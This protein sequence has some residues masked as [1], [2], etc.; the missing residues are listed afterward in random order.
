[1]TH[2]RLKSLIG[3]KRS[4][5]IVEV[6]CAFGILHQKKPKQEEEKDDDD[7]EGEEGMTYI[8][9]KQGPKKH[10]SLCETNKLRTQLL[11][12]IQDIVNLSKRLLL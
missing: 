3:N 12:T 2:G 4:M 8:L 10:E 7:E 6:L 11:E 1:V 5:T 9:G